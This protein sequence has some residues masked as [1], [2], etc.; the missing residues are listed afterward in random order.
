MAT[1]FLYGQV[2][3]IAASNVPPG[4]FPDLSAMLHGE[5]SNRGFLGLR[6]ALVSTSSLSPVINP[7]TELLVYNSTDRLTKSY[8]SIDHRI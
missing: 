6:P 5:S 8:E 3:M 2:G 1:I 7:K 4:N